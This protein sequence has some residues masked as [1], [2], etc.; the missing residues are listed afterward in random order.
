MVN[1]NHDIRPVI[2]VVLTTPERGVLRGAGAETPLCGPGMIRLLTA[3]DETGNV[4]EAC[5]TI[6]LSYSKAWK[7]LRRFTALLGEPA[8]IRQQGGT[9]G[10]KAYLSG[11]CRAFL[12]KHRSFLSACQNAVQELFERYYP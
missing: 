1:L 11:A 4:R 5:G 3:I 6:G 9:G 7:L 12:E 8:V 2:K 10:G